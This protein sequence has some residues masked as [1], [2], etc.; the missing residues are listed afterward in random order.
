[1]LSP[2]QH[3]W[4]WRYACCTTHSQHTALNAACVTA[5]GSMLWCMQCFPSL[6]ASMGW[7]LPEWHVSFSLSVLLVGS[8]W[9][10]PEA[11]CVSVDV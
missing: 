10:S 11:A 8:Q 3:A 4:Q 2:G 6:F 5:S 7:A 1:M 9:A